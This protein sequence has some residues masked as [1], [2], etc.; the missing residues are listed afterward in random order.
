[1][2]HSKT[3]NAGQRYA[4]ARKKGVDEAELAAL[5]VAMANRPKVEE[6]DAEERRNIQARIAESNKGGFRPSYY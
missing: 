1:M 3:P 6:V 5:R 2:A 4:S